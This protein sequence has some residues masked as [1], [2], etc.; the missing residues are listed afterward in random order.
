[1]LLD[2]FSGIL[3]NGLG[4]VRDW[5][6]GKREMAQEK[7]KLE[8]QLK[9][10]K[11][12]S[13]IRRADADIVQETELVEQMA[14]SWK[15]EFWTIVLAF[16]FI[17]VFL[18]S[19]FGMDETIASVKSAFDVLHGLPEWYRYFLG[20]A[21]GA[22]FGVRRLKDMVGAVRK[23]PMKIEKVRHLTPQEANSKIEWNV[24]K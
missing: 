22:A 14:S 16:P 17:V 5:L 4:M 20:I 12:Q 21:I 24:E 9:L 6:Q 2:I 23:E 18:A 10:S 8:G 19:M 15:D 3:G 1:M 13:E 11:L 7:Q